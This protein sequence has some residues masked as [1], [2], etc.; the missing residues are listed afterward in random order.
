MDAARKD[1][2]RLCQAALLC[3]IAEGARFLI[4]RPF[5]LSA[6]FYIRSGIKSPLLLYY[7]AVPKLI[8][9]ALKRLV[10]GQA[11]AVFQA[12]SPRT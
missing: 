10:L 8:D 6:F 11:L 1:A 2:G 9:Q 7:E 5:V 4:T 3:G 12:F